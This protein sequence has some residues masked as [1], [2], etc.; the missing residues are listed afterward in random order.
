[1][2]ELSLADIVSGC[3]ALSL[4]AY[5]LFGGADFGGG[6]WDLLASG[7]R[8]AHQRE[9]ITSA[10]SPIW[11]ANHVWLILAIV[12]TFTCFSPVF[13]RLGI[14]LHIP[15][16]LM[17]IGIVLRGSAFTFRTYD[18]QHDATQ[19]RWGRIFS[20]ASVITPVLL[21]ISIGAVA[22]GRVGQETQGGFVE[23]FVNPWFTPFALSVGLLTLTIFAFLAAVYLTLETRDH[24]LAEDFRRRALGSGI[25]VFFASALVLLLSNQAAPLV[26]TGL[27]T[28]PWALPLHL[29]TGL[30]AIAVLAALRFRR[31]RLARIGVGLQVSLIFWGWPM[32]QYP[33][34]LPPNYTI[35]NSAAPETTLRL[36]LI[37]LA[38]GGVIL[39]P[40]LWYLFQVFKSVPADP[41]NRGV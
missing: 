10:L 2:P 12:L 28:S 34:L 24:E 40:S 33:F 30:T 1:V 26:R 8:R 3:L 6:V 29:V 11:E 31:Y 22:S 15:L 25:A 17:L 18:S 37:G 20:S 14:V 35:A 21:G 36:T 38:I 13:A 9:V 5:V 7:P 27:M 39:L 4:N 41:G 19:R 32:A 23:R 16:T